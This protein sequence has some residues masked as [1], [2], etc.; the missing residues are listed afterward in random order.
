M[1]HVVHTFFFSRFFIFFFVSG[2]RGPFS[3]IE[4]TVASTYTK[5][6]IISIVEP[7]DKVV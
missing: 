6:L 7:Y 5:S 4:L 3:G 2:I 1:R